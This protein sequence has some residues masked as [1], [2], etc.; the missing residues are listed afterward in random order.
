MHGL[1]PVVLIINSNSIFSL[2]GRIS[3]GTADCFV[4]GEAVVGQGGFFGKVGGC[5]GSQDRAPV[6]EHGVVDH[7]ANV[8]QHS[9]PR[10]EAGA[11]RL[12]GLAAEVAG[13]LHQERDYVDD[14]QQAGERI[15][16]VAEV[17]LQVE[18]VFQDPEGIVLDLPPRPRAS[19]QVLDGIAADFEIGGERVVVSPPAGREA[20]VISNQLKF[21]ASSPSLIGT[22][23]IH[24]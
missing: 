1:R 11:R 4:C 22:P 21:R 8:I 20:T 2:P 13:V 3:K 12:P 19:C 15:P 18:A 24:R 5:D 23:L 17:A 6:L 10:D 7:G 9:I 14:R 16:A